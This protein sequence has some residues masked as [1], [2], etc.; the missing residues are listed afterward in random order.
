MFILQGG[1]KYLQ[2][3]YTFVFLGVCMIILKYFSFLL[4]KTNYLVVSVLCCC[5]VM[6]N[7]LRPH[8]MQ[9]ARLPCSS[10]SPRACSNSCPS[11][12][13][14]HPTISFVISFSFCLKIFP[15][16]RIFSIVGSLHHVAK[17]LELQVHH[18]SFRFTIR[19]SNEYSVLISLRLAGLISLQA[20][21]LTRVFFSTTVQ[22]HQFFGA[23]PSLWSNFPVQYTT[24]GKKTNKQKNWLCRLLSA[25]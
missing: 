25:K 7:S 4:N 6:S 11:S 2:H 10:P 16:S 21:G 23:Q 20:K 14:C 12:W 18:E 1:E 3:E 13:W 22:K 19:P 17:V 5:S 15:A 8:G 9:H 24:T